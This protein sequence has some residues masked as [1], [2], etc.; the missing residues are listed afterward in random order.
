MEAANEP[1]R[2]TRLDGTKYL[3]KANSNV[4]RETFSD[5]FERDIYNYQ[6]REIHLH[7]FI[8]VE[9]CAVL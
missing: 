6:K 8:P 3:T 2:W 5:G 7:Q 4:T 9:V 1:E